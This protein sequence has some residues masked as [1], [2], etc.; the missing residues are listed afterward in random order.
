MTTVGILAL[1]DTAPA[2]GLLS[3]AALRTHRTEAAAQAGRRWTVDTDGHGERTAWVGSGHAIQPLFRAHDLGV[4]APALD[5][6]TA[7]ANPEHA[8]A[9]VA[10]WRAVANEMDADPA[11]FGNGD[12]PFVWTA[13]VTAA[14]AYLGGVS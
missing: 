11:R 5:H 4:L 10:L 2:T 3:A 13:A 12:L 6:I 8:L 9:E 14:R 7:E 1:L